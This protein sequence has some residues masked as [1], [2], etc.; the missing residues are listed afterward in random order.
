[1]FQSRKRLFPSTPNRLFPQR[2]R[3]RAR[4][5][6]P[7]LRANPQK[8]R[9]YPWKDSSFSAGTKALPYEKI[10]PQAMAVLRKLATSR[11]G[12]A[13]AITNIKTA[14]NAIGA[15]DGEYTDE[16]DDAK[17]NFRKAIMLVGCMVGFFA[18]KFGEGSPQIA[19][20]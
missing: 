9:V 17:F 4:V 15:N 12:E 6:V 20:V 1:M 14:L 2:Q 11:S 10:Y 16:L 5:H 18:N 19:D 3:Q 7:P 13:V 8:C